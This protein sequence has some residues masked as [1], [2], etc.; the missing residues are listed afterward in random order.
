M[1][2][3]GLPTNSVLNS[4]APQWLHVWTRSAFAGSWTVA[5]AG[6]DYMVHPT[7]H[8]RTRFRKS[9]LYPALAWLVKNAYLKDH[10]KN[11]IKSLLKRG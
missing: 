2:D 8:S 1:Q 6:A 3:T 7:E 9:R 5:G 11:N 10:I 4:T